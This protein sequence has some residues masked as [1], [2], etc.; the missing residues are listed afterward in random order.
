MQTW[1]LGTGPESFV[2][3]SRCGVALGQ[4]DMA[5]V[6][7]L[8]LGFQLL[9]G[10]G[11]SEW[12]WFKTSDSGD[13]LITNGSESEYVVTSTAERSELTIKN[14]DINSD[15]GSYNSQGTV[16]ERTTLCVKANPRHCS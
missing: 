7:L 5:A 8:A 2:K 4:G 16:Q 15:P 10:Q 3:A 14:L 11:A 9:G 12:T 1:V 6:L 13:Q